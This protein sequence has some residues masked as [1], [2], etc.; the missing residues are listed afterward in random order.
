MAVYEMR[1]FLVPWFEHSFSALGSAM[2][3]YALVI[4]SYG[5]AGRVR[6]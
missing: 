6:R 5:M 1:S 2:T 4:W 3:A